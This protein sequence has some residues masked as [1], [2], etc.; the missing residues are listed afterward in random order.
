ME[1]EIKVSE[2]PES[3]PKA[4]M[5]RQLILINFMF[6][7]KKYIKKKK[8]PN[9]SIDCATP[10]LFQEFIARIVNFAATSTSTRA[11]KRTP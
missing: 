1:P 6:F 11:R 5:L 2:K 7:R 10:Q 9:P 3:Q 4:N 8:K